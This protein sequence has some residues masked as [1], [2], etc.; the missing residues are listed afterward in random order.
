VSKTLAT[1]DARKVALVENLYIYDL[2]RISIGEANDEAN[3][4]IGSVFNFRAT[5]NYNP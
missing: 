2:V 1:R 3:R 4:K 5:V